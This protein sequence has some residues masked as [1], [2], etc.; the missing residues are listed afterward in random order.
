MLLACLLGG[1]G[2]AAQENPDP[3]I[4]TNAGQFWSL[5][6]E[7]RQQ[8]HPLRLEFTIT[9]Y[10]AAWNV[11]WGE[12][13]G[14]GFFLPIHG[15]ALPMR[16]G[17]RVRLEGKVTPAKGI[18]G[19]DVTATV[20]D[21][22]AWTVP[23]PVAGRLDDIAALDTRR[24]VIEGYVFR[25]REVG[26]TH[27]NLQLLS[28]GR[29]INVQVLMGDNDPIPQF[30]GA[31]VRLKGLYVSNRDVAGGQ[32]RI[33]IW[34]PR[35]VDAEVIGW[36]V[37]DERFHLPRT[38]I[39]QLATAARGDWVH[40][41]GEVRAQEPDK[42]ITVRDE[43]G[44][45]LIETMQPETIPPGTTIEVVGRPEEQAGV[46]T[47]RE[48]VFRRTLQSVQGAPGNPRIESQASLLKLRLAD[49]VLAL[50]AD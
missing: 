33:D 1:G 28:E 42:S 16:S 40:V 50:S 32:P 4:L 31:R 43:A 20:L 11:L 8:S 36:L 3:A 30:L 5:G 41:I 46:W 14:V 17:Q 49:Q 38:P 18:A 9:Y 29:L 45:L 10:D 48:P 24:V 22:N 27:V 12:N 39:D 6:D 13:Q 21:N 25:Q 35:M 15:R 37:Q 19:E 23:L 2:V 7:A 34:V 44:Q 47:L 26:P